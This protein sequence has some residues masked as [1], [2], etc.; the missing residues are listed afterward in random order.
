MDDFDKKL[1]HDLN[2]EIEVPK[3]FTNIIKE[4]L[5][6]DKIK[7]KVSHYSLTKIISVA[8]ASL[9]LTAGIAYA[10]TEIVKNIWKEPEKVVSNNNIITAEEK[11]ECITKEKA[12]A[13]ANE[14]F[15]KFGYSNEKIKST[16]LEKS[17]YKTIDWR[18]ET[19]SEI[20]LAFCVI[21]E[22]V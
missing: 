1:Y 21:C 9:V 3:E 8:C 20:S 15:K 11:A 14:I 12:T 18:F 22:S 16:T 4:S 6:N 17:S 13:K 2:L 7:K 5:N 19:E 10:S